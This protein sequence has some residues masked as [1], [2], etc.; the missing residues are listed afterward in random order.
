MHRKCHRRRVRLGC[1]LRCFN[2]L[3]RGRTQRRRCRARHEGPWRWRKGTRREQARRRRH[4]WPRRGRVRRRRGR[5]SR[6]SGRP[7]WRRRYRPRRTRSERHRRQQPRRT[8]LRWHFRCML[9]RHGQRLQRARR[10]RPKRHGWHL[11]HGRW[12]LAQRPEHAPRRWLL[13]WHPKDTWRQR[14]PVQ[15]QRHSE[16]TRR[17]RRPWQRHAAAAARESATIRTGAAHAPG[18]RAGAAASGRA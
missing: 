2:V 14:L 16:L 15:R 9:P 12:R 11:G 5:Q 8:R 18:V 10:G 1:C 7:P 6:S 13:A 3:L 4:G 17:G